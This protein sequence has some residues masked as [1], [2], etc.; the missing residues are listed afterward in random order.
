M[1]VLNIREV[2]DE[3]AQAV[4][5]EAAA[6][7]LNLREWIIGTLAA[8]CTSRV[9][10]GKSGGARPSPKRRSSIVEA[11]SGPV[12]PAGEAKG[13]MQAKVEENYKQAVAE[14]EHAVAEEFAGDPAVLDRVAKASRLCLRPCGALVGQL[15]R[16]PAGHKGGCKAQP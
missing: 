11:P 14:L 7:G 5:I 10:S 16:L 12:L 13:P 6:A 3:V 8:A 4:K 1:A 2:P 15:C 9:V